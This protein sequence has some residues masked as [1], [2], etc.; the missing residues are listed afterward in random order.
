MSRP[1]YQ[2]DFRLVMHQMKSHKILPHEIDRL[3]A[4]V[5]QWVQRT[6]KANADF[7]YSSDLE[8]FT[9]PITESDKDLTSRA[10]T[11]SIVLL[12]NEDVLPLENKLKVVVIG[13][14]A[15]DKVATGG[16][17]AQVRTSWCQSPWEALVE[18]KPDGIDLKY[19]LGGHIAKYLPILDSN[20]TC[21]DGSPGFD[22]KHYA[23]QADGKQGRDPVATDKHDLSHMFMYDFYHPRLGLHYFT[24]LHT[25][26]TSPVD[27]SYDLGFCVTGQGWLYVD[28]KLVIENATAE[29]QGEGG[30]AFFGFGT[31]EVSTTLQ[32]KKGQ[33]RLS[34]GQG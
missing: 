23:I 8:E 16:G 22:L 31:Q 25:I 18:T 29:Q 21:L 17:S 9:R 3:A 6:A 2:A 5:L 20:F 30:T 33:V 24:E 1:S 14:G 28:D 4:S 27:G 7:V 19:S 12:K 32:V 13:A 34:Q 11:E 26:F 15:K 10:A